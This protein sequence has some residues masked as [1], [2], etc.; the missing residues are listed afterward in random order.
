[1]ILFLLMKTVSLLPFFV[2]TTIFLSRIIAYLVFPVILEHDEIVVSE[3]SKL[4]FGELLE[5]VAAEPHPPG[6]YLLLKA[7]PFE[8]KNLVKIFLSVIGFFLFTASLLVCYRKGLAQ[9]YGFTFGLSLFLASNL[10]VSVFSTLKQDIISF[11]LLLILFFLAIYLL[12]KKKFDIKSLLSIHILLVI[13]LF[14]GYIAYAVG[15]LLILLVTVYYYKEKIPKLLFGFQLSVLLFYIIFFG[16]EQILIN[17]GRL[18]WIRGV[19]NSFVHS[20]SR[21]LTGMVPES[22]SIDVVLLTFFTFLLVGL[23][24]ISKIKKKEV[25]FGLAIIFLI[26]FFSAYVT[27][28]FVRERYTMFLFFLASLIWGWGIAGISRKYKFLVRTIPFFIVTLLLFNILLFTFQRKVFAKKTKELDSILIEKSEGKNIGLLFE[29]PTIA[30]TYKK[31][32]NLGKNIVPINVFSPGLSEKDLVNRKFLL[33]EANFNNVSQ[34]DIKDRFGKLNLD[35]Y[36][37]LFSNREN[38]TF[39]RERLVF[40]QIEVSCRK[41]LVYPFGGSTTLYL[42]EECDF[43]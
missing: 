35:G 7:I 5:T 4:P 29:H 20:A 25:G 38:E 11:P 31:E 6:F 21:F 43:D 16:F 26:L 28:S 27:R 34:K 30:F 15:L 24:H 9:K 10:V 1:M 42:F 22:L 36:F 2:L 33:A 32:H 12:E 8:E 19:E 41:S 14:L 17:S 3:I 40:R 13:L 18:E 39:D 37:Y 23:R